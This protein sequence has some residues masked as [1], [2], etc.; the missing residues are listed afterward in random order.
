MRSDDGNDGIPDGSIDWRVEDFLDTGQ[1]SLAEDDPWA[2]LPSSSDEAQAV[3]SNPPPPS[4][5][6]K[7][8]G[9]EKIRTDEPDLPDIEFDIPIG[10]YEE[11]EPGEDAATLFDD[12]DDL[13]ETVWD[14]PEPFAEYD[15]ELSEDLYI[16]DDDVSNRSR[17]IK[18]DEFVARVADLTHAQQGQVT[19]LLETL[20]LGRLSSWLPWLREKDWTGHSLLLFLEFRLI[21]WEE[22]PQWWESSFWNARLDHWW[23]Y[24]NSSTL[25]LEG[26]FTLV[27][28]RLHC[29][30][31]G[32]LD[33]I[34]FNDWDDYTVWKRGFPSFAAFAIF[35]AGL[36][37]GENWLELLTWYSEFAPSEGTRSSA[38]YESYN[39]RD[40]DLPSVPIGD[41]YRFW[42]DH[43]PYRNS[44]GTLLWFAAQ[45]WY[46]PS[47]WHDNL[48]WACGWLDGENP[49]LPDEALDSMRGLL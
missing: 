34:W 37:D 35:R 1:R 20:S 39:P 30:P 31:D 11:F 10:E 14:E 2:D 49:Y 25:S 13:N 6:P 41:S 48:D 27:Q 19:E 32:V 44:N 18:I 43:S 17:N 16:P 26:A 40:F 28:S 42:E 3:G 21:Q 9:R 38:I 47:E 23:A 29:S 5:V 33:E 22:N 36:L 24:S 8:P 45:D 12:I 46:D 4:D 15:S 7:P